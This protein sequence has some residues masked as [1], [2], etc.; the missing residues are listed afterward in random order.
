VTAQTG[1]PGLN[2]DRA[3]SL[4]CRVPELK[5]Q[6][7]IVEMISHLD[8]YIESMDGTIQ[9]VINLRSGL[10][11]NLLSGAHEIPASYDKVMDAA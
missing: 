7:E 4:K 1:V 9:N 5:V 2:R 11:S 6:M 8:R 3:Y 10:L